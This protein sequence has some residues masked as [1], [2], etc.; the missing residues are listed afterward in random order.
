LAT[1]RYMVDN[2]SESC[3][4][5]TTHFGFRVERQYGEAMAILSKDDLNLWLAGPSSSAAQP[6]KDG[7]K[8]IPGGWNRFVFEIDDID[9][10]VANLKSN[11][12]KFKSEIIRGGGRSQ[13]LCEDPSGNVIELMQL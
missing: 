8:P 9:T 3:E 5:Y 10:M 4:F 7:S 1:V 2:V 6:M 13:I 11:G 12:M